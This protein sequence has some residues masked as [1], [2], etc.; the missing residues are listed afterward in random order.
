[1]DRWAVGVL[2]GQGVE[3]EAAVSLTTAEIQLV[4]DDEHIDYSD[5]LDSYGHVDEDGTRFR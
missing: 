1:M 2:R 5:A 3:E 4:L